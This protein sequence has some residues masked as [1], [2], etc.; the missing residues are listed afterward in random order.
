MTSR[1]RKPRGGRSG[2]H[3]VQTSDFTPTITTILPTLEFH[4]TRITKCVGESPVAAMMQIGNPRAPGQVIRC[5]AA[6]ADGGGCRVCDGER[7]WATVCGVGG[8]GRAL[9]EVAADEA[10]A[11]ANA[12]HV[13]LADVE[14]GHR[15]HAPELD[16]RDVVGFSRLF[17][18]ACK[19]QQGPD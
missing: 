6:A 2:R 11:R 12:L 15:V 4:R 1:H 9:G 10:G 8:G 19:Y 5:P 13:V 3:P 14:V 16:G 17:L 7:L 18:S